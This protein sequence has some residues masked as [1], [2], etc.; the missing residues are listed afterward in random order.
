MRQGCDFANLP[1]PAPSALRAAGLSFACR[2]V[3]SSSTIDGKPFTLA[4]ARQLAEAGIDVVSNWE[5]SQYDAKRS[6]PG[7]VADAREAF[8]NAAACGMPEERP[9]YFSVDWDVQPADLP[10]I[11]DYFHGIVSVLGVDRTGVYGGLRAVA[12][13]SQLGLAKWIWQTYAWSGGKWH[14]NAHIRQTKNDVQVGGATVDLDSAMTDD[15]GQ[16]RPD[17]GTSMADYGTLGL[18]QHVPDWIGQHPDIMTADVHAAITKGASGWGDGSAVW[19]VTKLGE[20]EAKID[21]KASVT[22]IDYDMLAAAL[23]RQIAKAA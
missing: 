19:L 7:G 14:P 11:R 13:L 2:Y 17:G 4:E 5:R 22:P 10:V 8:R 1:R 15:F 18:P 12:D 3:V 9:I 23:L 21:A 16:W 20:I 6:F